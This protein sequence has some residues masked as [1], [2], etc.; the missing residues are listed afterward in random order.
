MK[1]NN[2]ITLTIGIAIVLGIYAV[3]GIAQQQQQQ[4]AQ[5]APPFYVAVIDVA[6][7]IKQHP[8]FMNRQ[9]TLQEEIKRT[10]ATFQ[11]R[12]ETIA[13]KQKGLE[14]SQFKPGTAEYQQMIDTIANEVADFERDARTQQR[15]FALANSQIMYDTYQDIKTTIGKYATA[16]GIAQVT[17]Y[18]DFEPN[19]A[20][21]QTVAEDMDQRLVW[22]NPTLNIT[23]QIIGEVYAARGMQPPAPTASGSSAG[24]A[25]ANPTINLPVQR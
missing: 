3:S 10:E 20:D 7:V 14:T 22:F 17:D 2:W 21:P 8:E 5:Q 23:R 19:P 11:T 12:Q 24:P 6:Q 15:R 18:R 13:N 16:R 9:A 1:K 25:V 4:A